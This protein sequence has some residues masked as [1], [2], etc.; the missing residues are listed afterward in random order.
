MNTASIE[1][2]IKY[3]E[4]HVCRNKWNEEKRKKTSSVPSAVEPKNG[5]EV[6]QYFTEYYYNLECVIWNQMFHKH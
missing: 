6:T 4:K 3:N 5:F 2:A 1:L